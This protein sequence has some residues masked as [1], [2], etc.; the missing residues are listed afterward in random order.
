MIAGEASRRAI[1]SADDRVLLISAPDG[2]SVTGREVE[3]ETAGLALALQREGLADR[4]VGLWS[5]NSVAAIEAHLAVEWT[6]GT[7]VPVDPGAPPAEA[8]AIFKAAEVAGVVVAQV[9]DPV[10]VALPAAGLPAVDGAVRNPQ[11][12][13][14]GIRILFAMWGFG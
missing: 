6:G 12:R 7:R 3:A 2:R 8:A 13:S 4:R 5:W 10:D 11:D 14:F 1:A 9:V